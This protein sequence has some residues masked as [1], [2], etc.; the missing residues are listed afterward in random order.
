MVVLGR[1]AASATEILMFLGMIPE[2]GILQGRMLTE[3]A[4]LSAPLEMTEFEGP[5]N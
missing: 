1:R 2:M 4:G 5:T 3:T